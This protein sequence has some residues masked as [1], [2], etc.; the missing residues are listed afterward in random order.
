M[1]NILPHTDD[2]RPALR[3]AAFV[4]VALALAPG[5]LG[6]G[7]RPRAASPF[8]AEIERLSEP[9]GTF[10]TDNLISNER[11]YLEVIP[12]LMARGVTGGAY[13]GVGPDQ[14]F[15]Y[16]ARIRPIVAFIIDVRRDNLLLHLLFKAIF[17]AR[18]QRASNT[19]RCSP[20]GRRPTTSDDGGAHARGDLIKHVDEAQLLAPRD[21]SLTD[22]RRRSRASVSRWR[23]PTTTPSTRF[24]REFI[25]HGLDLQFRSLSRSPQ[26]YYPTLRELMLATDRKDQPWSYLASEDDFRFLRGLQTRDAVIPVVGDVAGPHA[27]RAI[28]AAIRS[29]R[30][31]I[32]AFYISNV[33]NYL[34]RDNAFPAYADN[35]SRLPLN[36][37][38]VIIRSI[39]MGSG[40]SV[41]FVQ[42]L[43]GM[44]ESIARGRYTSYG[45]IV[46]EWHRIY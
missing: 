1:R 42:P 13:V 15:S 36:Q 35:L 6:L 10:D 7:A 37:R 30:E 24:H 26:P 25:K 23:T 2:M 16:I 39:F 11:A 46:R 32:S 20:A 12:A 41:S 45:D 5:T 4:L 29:R 33:E 44:V 21:A 38:S 27:M 14:N 28:G 18:R 3:R 8:A 9:G 19:W 43:E 31:A 22:A 17:A 40:Q 34:F